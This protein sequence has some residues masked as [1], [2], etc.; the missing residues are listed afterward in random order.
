MNVNGDYNDFLEEFIKLLKN[1]NIE[2]NVNCLKRIKN[3][4]NKDLFYKYQKYINNKD[5]L[6]LSHSRS[7]KEKVSFVIL[8][9]NEERVIKRCIESI[10]SIADEIIVID[11][12]SNDRTIEIIKSLNSD[13]IHVYSIKWINDF[14]YARNIGIDKASGDWIFFIDADEYIEDN[15]SYEEIR[16]LFSIFRNTLYYDRFY[17]CPTISDTFSENI[18][19]NIPRIFIK[20]QRLHYYGKVHE[21]I[22]NNLDIPLLEI[23]VSILIKHDGYT[24]QVLKSKNKLERNIT[25]LKDMIKIEPD[26]PRWKYF[27]VR[28]SFFNHNPN[29]VYL[30]EILL[31]F[32]LKDNSKFLQKSNI[33]MNHYTVMSLDLLCRIEIVLQNYNNA[34][35]LSSYLFE[36]NPNSMNA[37]YYQILSELLF[38]K[39]KSK[40]LLNDVIQF[41]KRHFED[42]PNAISTKGYH[43]DLLIAILLFENMY[44]SQSKKYFEFLKDKFNDV[45]FQINIQNYLD[46]MNNIKEEGGLYEK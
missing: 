35:L 13:I 3:I 2:Y 8:T 23:H 33:V 31:S 37:K 6:N 44:Y 42:Q 5:N 34:K 19:D 9:Y 4:S 41:R 25:L 32:L 22:R 27:F 21:E 26:N 45:E 16:D 15:I 7:G 36:L 40:N 18:L 39:L 38:Y 24:P 28:D 17:L 46:I 1:N 29:L 14:S 20:S 12:Q 10:L 11:S 43:L 30:K